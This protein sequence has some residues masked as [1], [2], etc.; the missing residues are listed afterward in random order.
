MK[1]LKLQ[2]VTRYFGYILLVA[3][4]FS[5]CDYET[6]YPS[7]PCVFIV[8]EVVQVKGGMQ[9]YKVEMP[10]DEDTNM[11]STSFYFADSIGKFNAG[12]TLRFTLNGN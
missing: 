12:D 2:R 9:K 8:K 1:T 11:G 4:L 6:T 7:K 3:V 10:D 5:S